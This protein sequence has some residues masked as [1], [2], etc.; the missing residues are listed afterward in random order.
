VKANRRLVLAALGAGIALVAT[1]LVVWLQVSPQEIGRSDFTS[2]YV[3]ADL[4][5]HGHHADL[6]DRELQTATHTALIAPDHEGNLPFVNPPLAAVVAT[7]LTAFGLDTAYRIFAIVQFLLLVAAVLLVG[8]GGGSAGRVSDMA[9]ALAIP[10]T[11]ALLLLGQWD[12]LSA[13]GLAAGYVA[14]KRERGFLGGF[15]LAA[16]LLLAK[17][18]LALGVACFLVAWR[19]R[20]VLAGAL[21]GAV[22][23]ALANLAAVGFSGIAGFFSMAS[24]DAT[25]WTLSS[26]LGFNGFF[27][28]WIQNPAAAQILGTAAS[29]AALAACAW[30]GH[31]AFKGAPLEICLA[32]AVVLSLVASP[33]LLTQDLVLLCPLYVAVAMSRPADELPERMPVLMFAG[34]SGLILCSFADIGNQ[35]PAPPGR[36]VPVAL[37]AIAAAMVRTLRSSYAITTG[38]SLE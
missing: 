15:L 5:S 17:P 6:Y 38:G 10:G 22:V 8:L 25:R 23:V 13:L 21:T 16:L 28:S 12:G 4:W 2:T 7:P 9:F 35:S 19:Q 27:D 20:R 1:Y 14:V 18:H 30:A 33:H 32:F 31:R 24:Y 3:G 37:V 34:W 29:L 11:L 36:L 26:F